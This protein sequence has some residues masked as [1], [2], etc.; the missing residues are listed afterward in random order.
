MDLADAGIV[1][2]SEL[3]PRHTVLTVDK[4]DFKVYRRR[5]GKPVPCDFA[6]D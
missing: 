4:A 2:L 5:D 3:H 6:P 1:R